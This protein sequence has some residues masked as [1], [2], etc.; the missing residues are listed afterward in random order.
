MIGVDEVGRGPAIGPLVVASLAVP[1]NDV[2]KLIKIG[3][4][5]SK[6][7]VSYTHLRAHET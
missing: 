7:T 3:V 6:K 5:D 4:R 1:E 2:Q